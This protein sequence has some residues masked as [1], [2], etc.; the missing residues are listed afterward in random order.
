METILD[1]SYIGK[2][3][4]MDLGRNL[5]TIF[6]KKI[7]QSSINSILK[8]VFDKCKNMN[9]LLNEK[10]SVHELESK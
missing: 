8:S 6:D 3:A 4:T 2:A 1:L 10:V 9:S 7:F 5:F